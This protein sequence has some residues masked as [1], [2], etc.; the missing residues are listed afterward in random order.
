[1]LHGRV[2]IT[3]DPF[4]ADMEGGETDRGHW[5]ALQRQEYVSNIFINGFAKGKDSEDILNLSSDTFQGKNV[6]I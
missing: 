4:S 6:R 1:M 2:S 5:V 3:R